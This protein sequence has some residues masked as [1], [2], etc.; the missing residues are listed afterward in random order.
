M[1]GFADSAE[2]RVNMPSIIEHPPDEAT[3]YK[4]FQIRSVVIIDKAETHS[5]ILTLDL[6]A[7]SEMHFA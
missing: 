1:P 6:P 4:S 3:K 7:S 5:P 2:I